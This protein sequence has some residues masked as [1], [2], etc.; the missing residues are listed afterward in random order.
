MENHDAACNYDGGDC[1]PNVDRIGDGFCDEENMNEVCEY[2]GL[3]CCHNWQSVEDRICNTENNN[4]YCKFDGGDC[5][6]AVKIGD[7]ICEDYNNN[8]IPMCGPY[9]LGDCCLDQPITLYCSDC[10]CHEDSMSISN[11]SQTT[12]LPFCNKILMAK[13]LAI[14]LILAYI[15]LYYIICYNFQIIGLILAQRNP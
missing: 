4:E 11:V 7:G 2:D 8:P 1:C 5:C 12:Y 9:D 6:V 13:S 10:K 14:C 3:D 15:Y